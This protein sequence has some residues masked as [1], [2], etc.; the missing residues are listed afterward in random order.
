MPLL[1][2]LQPALLRQFCVT[3]KGYVSW[4][5]LAAET[6]GDLCFFHGSRLPFVLRRREQGYQLI[7][8]CYLH[9][10]MVDDP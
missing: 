4:V 1:S 9:G 6:G 2:A 5:P 10:L 7:E 8:D 3:E